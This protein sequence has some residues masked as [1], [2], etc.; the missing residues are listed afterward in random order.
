MFGRG[1]WVKIGV[2]LAVLAGLAWSHTAAYRAGRTAEQARIVERITQEND[3]AAENA[4]DWR[5]EYRRCVAS[6]GLYDFESG[7]CGP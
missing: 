2:G 3:D 6:G 5:T 7:S 1:T 4:E